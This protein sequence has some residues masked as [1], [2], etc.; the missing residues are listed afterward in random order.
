VPDP[1]VLAEKRP[2]PAQRVGEIRRARVRV[3]RRVE[4]L[5]LEDDDEDVTNRR[6]YGPTLLGGS[7]C[8]R[9]AESAEGER[10][11]NQA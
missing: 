6:E 11:D 9:E 2:G 10:R 3:E 4:S 1:I 7:V 8:C 5:I